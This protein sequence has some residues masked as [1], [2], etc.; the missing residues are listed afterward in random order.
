M[1]SLQKMEWAEF[2]ARGGGWG[3]RVGK[4]MGLGKEI[5][6]WCLSGRQTLNDSRT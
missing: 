6:S 3:G 1:Q 4:K 2:R 5:V